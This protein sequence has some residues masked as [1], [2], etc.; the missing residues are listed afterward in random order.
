MLLLGTVLCY[1]FFMHTTLDKLKFACAHARG[2]TENFFYGYFYPVYI[3]LAVLLFWVANLQVVGFAIIIFT[4]CFLLIFYDDFTP[5]LPLIF[6]APMSFRTLISGFFTA[7]IV[8]LAILASLFISA[9]I[10]HLIKY[11]IKRPLFDKFF[12]V[13]V[14]LF[15]VLLFS[16]LFSGKLKYFS[17]GLQVLFMAGVVPMLI[18]F[19]FLNKINFNTKTASISDKCAKA[20]DAS[21]ITVR[22]SSVI[23]CCGR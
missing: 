5:I 4:A 7:E 8:I 3:A 13:C 21:S 9:L 15:I 19:L 10:Y 1:N 14:G 11:P 23:R 16:G 17:Y 20:C 6:M 12:F 22:P 2:K 18:H